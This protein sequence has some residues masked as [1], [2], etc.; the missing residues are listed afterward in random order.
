[1]EITNPSRIFHVKDNNPTMDYGIAVPPYGP[2]DGAGKSYIRGGWSYGIPSGVK[3]PYESWL[4]THWLSATKEAAGWFMMQQLRPSPMKEVNEDPFYR[5]AAPNVWPQLLKAMEK[6]VPVPITPV[7]DEI[8]K[9]LNQAM[10]D[11]AAK[12]AP[13]RDALR[14]AATGVQRELDAFWARQGR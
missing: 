7:D 13:A 1:M 11:V 10:A 2:R 3:F 6:D 14:E 12:K 4:L 9:V 5:Q 8:D